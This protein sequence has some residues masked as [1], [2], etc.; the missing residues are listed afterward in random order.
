MAGP[1][2]EALQRALRSRG[3]KILQSMYYEQYKK[4]PG[5]ADRL[6]AARGWE[7]AATDPHVAGR[8]LDIVL[9]SDR[10]WERR[11]ADDLIAVFLRLRESMNWA[12]IVYNEFEWNSAGMR[13][14]RG[15]SCDPKPTD[16]EETAKKK[17]ANR[18]ICMHYSHIH[19]E[20]GPEGVKDASF[21]SP[22]GE[23][24]TK[25]ADPSEYLLIGKWKAT[26]GD[27][28]GYFIFD[29]LFSSVWTDEKTPESR[30]HTGKWTVG[31]KTIEWTFR[32][33]RTFRID[34]PLKVKMDGVILP[35]GQGFFHMEREP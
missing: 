32:D 1:A 21:E 6:Q 30:A 28:S 33:M 26:I 29:D 17:R 18:P 20:W 16:D 9:R 5:L 31:E 12:A 19:I 7:A 2:V 8:A 15:L 13:F 22:L 23:A 3:P 14:A 35:E 34:L 24:L 10:A 25:I 4:S 27:W 11:V